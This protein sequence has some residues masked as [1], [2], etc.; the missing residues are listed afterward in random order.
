MN[1]MK[2]IDGSTINKENSRDQ[3]A[4][5]ETMSFDG[6]N[7]KKKVSDL[8]SKT[9]SMGGHLRKKTGFT[10]NESSKDTGI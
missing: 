3:D 2:S 9:A 1:T 6:Y 8:R 4:N 7:E 5:T 10:N